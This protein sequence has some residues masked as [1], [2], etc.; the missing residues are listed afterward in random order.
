MDEKQK[1]RFIATSHIDIINAPDGHMTRWVRL[2][3]TFLSD[4]LMVGEGIC[5]LGGYSS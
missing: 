5:T 3:L 4:L 1:N 2:V